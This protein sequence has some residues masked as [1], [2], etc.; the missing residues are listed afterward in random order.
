MTAGSG[1]AT[2]RAEIRAL[3]D[4]AKAI[5]ARDVDR[6][7]SSYAPDVLLFDVVD[8]LRRTGADAGESVWRS[9]SLRSEARSATSFATSPSRRA[10][11][12]P[13]ATA[14]TV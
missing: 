1:K 2:A 11:T 5:R 14:P 6:S 13:S 8:P 7:L 3:V 4:Q 12:R 9:G 10:M